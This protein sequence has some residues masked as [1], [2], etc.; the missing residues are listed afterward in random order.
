MVF[1]LLFVDF[2]GTASS[3]MQTEDKRISVRGHASNAVEL[4]PHC[5]VPEGNRALLDLHHVE[6]GQLHL[7][8]LPLLSYLKVLQHLLIIVI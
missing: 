7:L 2:G 4:E 6:L 3:S 8:F 1:I 5:F